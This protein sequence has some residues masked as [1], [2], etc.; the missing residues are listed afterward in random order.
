MLDGLAPEDRTKIDWTRR[1]PTRRAPK[2]TIDGTGT[3]IAGFVGPDREEPLGPGECVTGLRPTRSRSYCLR[4]AGFVNTSLARL[5]SFMVASAAGS[6]LVSGC[7]LRCN[8]FTAALMTS[9]GASS[10]TLS[11]SYRSTSVGGLTYGR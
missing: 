11:T 7:H 8:A 6:G 4:L 2:S 1:S 10:A 9:G 3:G 5:T